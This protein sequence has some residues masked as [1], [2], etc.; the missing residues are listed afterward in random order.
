MSKVTFILFALLS[1]PIGILNAQTLSIGPMVGINSST[2]SGASNTKSLAGLNIGAFANY[3]VNEHVGISAKLLYSQLGTAY[4]NWEDINRLHY[5]QMPITGIYY[6]GKAENQFRP[7]IFLGPYIG[8][9]LDAT[10]KD[11]KKITEA[12]SGT[13]Y[14]KLDLGGLIGLGFNYRIKSRTWLNVDL[15]FSQGF[16]EVNERPMV[17]DKNQALSLNVGIS[18]PVGKY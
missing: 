11:A 17:P 6:F 2:Y 15:G 3:S 13:V 10:Y 18:F 8:R 12:N 7:K 16:T 9:L 1:I 4:K 5:L 14:N